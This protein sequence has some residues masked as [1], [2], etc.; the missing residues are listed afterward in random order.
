MAQES[1]V[2]PLAGT[3]QVRQTVPAVPGEDAVHGGGGQG[4]GSA[5][6]VRAELVVLPQSAD[7]GFGRVVVRCGVGLGRL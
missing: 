4:R 7:S 6:G 3:G 5:R 2:D 1:N